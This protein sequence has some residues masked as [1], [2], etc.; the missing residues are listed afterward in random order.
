MQW[1]TWWPSR[2]LMA[3]SALA[4]TP[5]LADKAHEHG[6]ARLD[7]VVE[8]QRI[9]FQ[10]D[11]PLDNLVGYE[12]APRDDAE[13]RQADAMLARLRE[14]ATLF[15]IDPAA[16]CKPAA[17][18]LGGGAR[19]LGASPAPET[20]KDGHADLQARYEF[21]CQDGWRAG[22]VEARLFDAFVRLQRVE[23]QAVTRKGQ[24]RATL[25]RPAGR[26]TLAR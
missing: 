14:P 21:S 17:V 18:E 4:A 3:L 6:I 2:L 20:A 24:L 7:I 13:R 11:T 22:F 8:A 5:V 15:T 23:I 9:T 10:L 16:G 12:R 26:V 25:R 1:S 19:L